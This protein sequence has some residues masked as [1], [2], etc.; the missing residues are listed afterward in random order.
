MLTEY[1]CENRLVT[2]ACSE[3]YEFV[4]AVAELRDVLRP[5]EPVEVRP[6]VVLRTPCR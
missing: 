3:S 2:F 4:G 6:A 1:P 5:A